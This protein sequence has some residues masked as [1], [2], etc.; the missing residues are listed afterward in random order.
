MH[1]IHEKLKTFKNNF[2]LDK[3]IDN[4]WVVFYLDQFVYGYKSLHRFYWSFND[5]DD[6]GVV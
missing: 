5:D 3:N 6:Y 4:R 2:Y 1:I